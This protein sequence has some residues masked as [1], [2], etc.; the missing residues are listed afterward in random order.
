[1][2]TNRG[3]SL[4]GD[5]MQNLP[6]FVQKLSADSITP[7]RRPALHDNYGP[8]STS[9]GTNV[10]GSTSGLSAAVCAGLTASLSVPTPVLESTSKATLDDVK[11][12]I[13][14]GK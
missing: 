8:V 7:G 4:F 1:M 10:T 12:K 13:K 5:S 14:V 3:L 9:T 2:A 11:P 6:D